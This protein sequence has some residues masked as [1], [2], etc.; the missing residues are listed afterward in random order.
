M[1]AYSLLA[2]IHTCVCVCVCEG[3]GCCI[4]WLYVFL[5]CLVPSQSKVCHTL[6][7]SLTLTLD[8]YLTLRHGGAYIRQ[9]TVS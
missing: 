3:V 6:K 1:K 5:A 4:N 8:S 2:Y 9:L 7:L